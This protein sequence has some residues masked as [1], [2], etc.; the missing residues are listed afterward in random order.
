VIVITCV[1]VA[2]AHAGALTA[3]NKTSSNNGI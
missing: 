3:I 1:A 2:P